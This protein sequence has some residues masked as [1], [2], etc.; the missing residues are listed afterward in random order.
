MFDA[1]SADTFRR[2]F[3]FSTCCL[4][5]GEGTQDRRAAG[6]EDAAAPGTWYTATAGTLLDSVSYA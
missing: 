1:P 3:S 4:G 6:A 2:A 5:L